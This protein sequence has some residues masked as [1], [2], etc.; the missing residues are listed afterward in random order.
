M[1]KNTFDNENE[2]IA[3]ISDQIQQL[4]ERTICIIC[5]GH[6]ILVP[7]K[8]NGGVKPG[9]FGQSE[10]VHDPAYQVI[11]I[12]PQYT[13]KIGCKILSKLKLANGQGSLSLLIND[14]QLMPPDLQRKPDQPNRYR[15]AFYESFSSLP[16]LYQTELVNHNLRFPDDLYRVSGKEFYL[17]EVRLRERFSRR[18]KSLV[19]DSAGEVSLG[20]CSL[21]L[22]RL[23]NI[24]MCTEDDLQVQLTSKSK[25][26]CAGGVCQMMID[27]SDDLSKQYDSIYFVNLMPS[28]C[29]HPVNVASELAL[30]MIGANDEILTIAITNLYFEGYYTFKEEDFFLE[31]NRKVNSASFLR[32]AQ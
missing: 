12:F 9:V 24:I 1:K 4:P 3:F 5:A 28:G 17:R 19:P 22:D 26:G 23:G 13:W 14:W 29:T 16:E 31:K 20:M 30:S 7:D 21:V 18:V 2:I 11:G 6:F 15:E 27:I 8:I 10:N 25:A 32:R